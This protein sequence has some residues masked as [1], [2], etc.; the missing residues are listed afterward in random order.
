[1]SKFT[2]SVLTYTALEHSRR[3]IQSI[4]ENSGDARDYD[5]ILTANGSPEAA[6]FFHSIARENKNVRVVVN[7]TNAGFIEP[8]KVALAMTE[9]PFFV[10]A[11]DD[12]IMPAGWLEAMENPFNEFP[13]CAI[14]GP[15]GGRYKYS[16]PPPDAVHFIE[17]SCMMGRTAI[18]KEVGLFSD[19]LKFCCYEECDLEMRLIA[20]GYTLHKTPFDIQHVGKATRNTIPGMAAIERRNYLEV[21]KRFPQYFPK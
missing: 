21:K 13:T 17:G 19:Y 2:I 3:C 20:K 12:T 15:T 4:L 16:P 6:K 18:L 1:M 10:L 5:L 7:E 8:S 14:S 11:N 9:T